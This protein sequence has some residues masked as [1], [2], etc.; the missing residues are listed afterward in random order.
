MMK[1]ITIASKMGIHAR[2]ASQIIALA[3]KHA[4]DIFL[5]KDGRTYNARSIMNILSMGM[6]HG[7][8]ILIS[9]EGF[10]SEI[11]IEEMATLILS[12]DN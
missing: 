9:A 11:A 5:I 2:P 1:K 3:Q 10:G 8:E 12:I 7:E 4:C 6:R